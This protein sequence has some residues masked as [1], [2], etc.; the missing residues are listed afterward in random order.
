MDHHHPPTQVSDQVAA[1][2]FL[3][4][5]TDSMLSSYVALQ[6]DLDE[7]YRKYLGYADIIGRGD[8]MAPLLGDSI[9]YP[10]VER[11]A[12]RIFGE[13]RPR[14]VQGNVQAPIEWTDVLRESLTPGDFQRQENGMFLCRVRGSLIEVSEASYLEILTGVTERLL[15]PLQ[16]LSDEQKETR[17]RLKLGAYLH[18]THE[19]L[20]Q[21]KPA[22]FYDLFGFQTNVTFNS[23]QRSARVYHCFGCKPGYS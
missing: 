5:E 9:F 14:L 8:L 20:V 11:T 23:C 15:Q 7:A 21:C 10:E 6:S 4:G 18:Q 2:S 12:A 13:P 22:H 16:N 19:S 1:P 3:S 17:A